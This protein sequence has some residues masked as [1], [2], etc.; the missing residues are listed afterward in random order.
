MDRKPQLI[1]CGGVSIPISDP[2]GIGKNILE[3]NVSGDNANVS[4]KIEDVARVFCKHIT[5]RFVDLLEIS[6]YVYAADCSTPREGWSTKSGDEQWKRDFTLIIPVRDFDFWKKPEINAQLCRILNFL[7]SDAWNFEFRQSSSGRNVD[8]FLEIGSEDWPFYD[9]ERVIMFSGGLD[10]L[11]GAVETVNKGEKLVLVSH[12]P[13]TIIDKRQ[14]ELFDEMK[15]L[16]GSSMTRI[17]VWVNKDV[18]FSKDYNQRT[19]SF[20]FSAL[21]VTVA[22]SLRAKGVRFFENGIVSLNWPLASEALQ[23]R[24][25]RTTHPMSLYYFTEFYRLLLEDK[26]FIIDNPYIFKT[27]SD[28]ISILAKNNGEKLIA[29]TCSCAHTAY[30]QRGQQHC[31]ACSQCIDRRIAVIAA[32]QL[33]NDPEE[34]YATDVFTGGR[35]EKYEQ[36]MAVQY[37]RHANLLDGMSEDDIASEFNVELSRAIRYLKNEKNPAIEIIRMHKRHGCE[38][39]KVVVNAFHE[40]AHLFFSNKIDPTSLIAKVGKLDHS[41][42]TWNQLSVRITEVLKS[43]LPKMCPIGQRPENENRLQQICDGILNGI[44]SDLIREFPFAPWSVVLTKPDFSSKKDHLWVELKYIRTK[45]DIR[46]ITEDIAAD[47][48]KYG[49]QGIKV[50][51]IVYDPDRLIRDET[52]FKMDIQKHEGMLVSLIY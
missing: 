10:S 13:V 9:V 4:L 41:Q 2:I 43:S 49:D 38:V 44:E 22:K 29:Y 15:K 30:K 26:D 39:K 27:K 8:S 51:F 28:V 11:T 20:L 36:A 1:L 47:I 3:F 24:A 52:R 33:D 48:T 12:R 50:L 31:G 6:A 7:S 34:D 25:S 5:G 42:T 17:P 18:K 40:N 23:S 19:R 16:Y 46:Q 45:S 37:V 32:G 35:K 21:G 14:R